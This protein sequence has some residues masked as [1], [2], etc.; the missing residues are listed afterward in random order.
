MTNK[1]EMML[2]LSDARGQYIPRDFANSF[3]DRSKHVKGVSEEEW[4][5]LEAGPDYEPNPYYWDVWNDVE[6][7]AVVT[8]ENGYEYFI[9]Q[10]G[11]CWLVPKGMEFNERTESFDWPSEEDDSEEYEHEDKLAD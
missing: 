6:N 10:N 4:T 9:W 2:W 8:D 3:V 11:D 7:N 1:P 5:I